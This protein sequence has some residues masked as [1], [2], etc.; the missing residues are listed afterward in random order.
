MMLV[1]LIPNSSKII[2][3]LKYV[4]FINRYSFIK[5]RRLQLVSIKSGMTKGLFSSKK[6]IRISINL[7]PEKYEYLMIVYIGIVIYYD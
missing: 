1:R 7:V 5:L 4:S 2:L 6:M 3:S